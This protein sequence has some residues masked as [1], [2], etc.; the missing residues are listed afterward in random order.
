MPPPHLFRLPAPGGDV[1]LVVD[2]MGAYHVV[3][4]RFPPLGLPLSETAV[5]DSQVNKGKAFVERTED[6]VI[7]N[8]ASTVGLGSTPN[9]RR[10]SRKESS[11]QLLERLNLEE[12]LLTSNF[13]ALK[14]LILR[15]ES[16]I[17]TQ[18]PSIN[19]CPVI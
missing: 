14:G 17:R 16:V 13:P 8:L 9:P 15:K 10:I 5:V 3:R 7:S 2:E 18:L 1:C 6:S 11:T 12:P 19:N 4:D